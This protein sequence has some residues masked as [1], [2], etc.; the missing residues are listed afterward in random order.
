MTTCENNKVKENVSN[1]NW[2][3]DSE[4][5]SKVLDKNNSTW[6]LNKLADILTNYKDKDN[7][8]MLPNT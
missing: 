3:K 2:E 4:V 5:L 6:Y 8:T 7:N 1:I